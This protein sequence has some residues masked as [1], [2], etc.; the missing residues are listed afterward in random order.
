MLLASQNFAMDFSSARRRSAGKPAPPTGGY[1]NAAESTSGSGAASVKG[2][3]RGVE[4]DEEGVSNGEGKPPEREGTLL[5]REGAP[6]CASI[7]QS[8]EEER[9]AAAWR[10][11]GMLVD[12]GGVVDDGEWAMLS[13]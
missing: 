10:G 7:A 5:E 2:R 6:A 12:G 8:P 4:S 1:R 3:E 9:A 13:L 11:G